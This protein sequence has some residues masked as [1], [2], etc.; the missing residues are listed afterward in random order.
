MKN[1][2]DSSPKIKILTNTLQDFPQLS[3]MPELGGGAHTFGRSVNPI[4]TR[5]G[6]FCPP[7]PLY[8]WH[9]QICSPSV[10]AVYDDVGMYEGIKIKTY[11]Q[12]KNV[13]VVIFLK[14]C[15]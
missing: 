5:L 15:A 8:Y 14:I 6:I 10:N 1:I 4:L 12:Q 13:Y 2:T 11:R 7:S 3:V 9:P